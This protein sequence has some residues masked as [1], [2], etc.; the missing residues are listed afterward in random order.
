[1]RKEKILRMVLAFV[2]ILFIGTG[3]SFNASAAL[4][5]DP[6][7][8]VYDG[9]RS[10]A[11]FSPEQLGMTSNVVN[12]V[13][14]ILVFITGRRYVNVGT[15]IYLLPYGIVVDLG[16]KLYH[17]IFKTQSLPFQITGAAIGCLMLYAGAAMFIT[18]DIGVDPFTGVVMVL[19][20]RLHREY[21]I[22]KVCFDIGCIV[23]GALLGGKLGVI[24]ILTAITAGPV[25]QFLAKIMGKLWKKEET[26]R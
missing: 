20:D 6:I 3:V 12:I 2:G 17:V 9:I 4:G 8:I 13:L 19:K 26:G 23:L 21:R 16:T 14:I 10:A 22:V 7:G 5:N 1:M 18:A 11:D 24:T 15:L 25:I